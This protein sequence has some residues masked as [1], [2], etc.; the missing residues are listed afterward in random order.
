MEGA[1]THPTRESP[2]ATSMEAQVSVDGC[3]PRKGNRGSGPPNFPFK[4]GW[5]YRDPYGFMKES[6]NIYNCVGSHPSQK[7]NYTLLLNKLLRYGFRGDEQQPR[8]PTPPQIEWLIDLRITC[9]EKE[10]HL[11]NPHLRVP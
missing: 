4:P 1:K 2:V 5:F 6:T 3:W 8:N 10:K 7:K 9:F 11:P